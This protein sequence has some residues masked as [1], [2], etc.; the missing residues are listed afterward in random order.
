MQAIKAETVKLI[1]NCECCE[2]SQY[3]ETTDGVHFVATQDC[4]DRRA[5]PHDECY[6]ATIGAAVVIKNSAR[7]ATFRRV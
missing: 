5:D 6:C 1:A 7:I 3:L 4:V 2:G